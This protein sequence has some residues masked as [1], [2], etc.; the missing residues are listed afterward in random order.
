MAELTPLFMFLVL[1]FGIIFLVGTPLLG[2]LI[3][4]LFTR[5]LK[6]K[7]TDFK[8]ALYPV[9]I[10]FGVMVAIISS[11][12]MLFFD[13]IQQWQ[14]VFTIVALLISFILGFFVV[15]KFYKESPA[16]CFGAWILTCLTGIIFFV[17]IFIIITLIFGTIFMKGGVN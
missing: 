16:K 3:L 1:I 15:F 12:S 14:N 2:A 17:I 8:T 13:K 6:F 10:V 5:W 11:L 4:S 7:K 9:L